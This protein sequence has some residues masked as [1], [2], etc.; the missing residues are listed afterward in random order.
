VELTPLGPDRAS[1]FAE[2]IGSIREGSFNLGGKRALVIWCE[3]GITDGRPDGRI[4]VRRP[5]RRS[6]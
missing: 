1:F 6:S 2:A 3:E 5:I 4:V